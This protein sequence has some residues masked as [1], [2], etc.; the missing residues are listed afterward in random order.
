MPRKIFS[1]PRAAPP[2]N[3]RLFLRRL[4][5]RSAA[6]AVLA[7]GIYS[8]WW[9]PRSCGV[10][11][12]DIPL[13]HLPAEFD[14]LTIAFLADTHHGPCVPLG[15]LEGVVAM[16]NALRPDLV[17][18]GGDYVHRHRRWRF[19]TGNPSYIAPGIKALGGLRARL[20]CFAV[21]GNHDRLVS[22]PRTQRAL[23]ENGLRELTNTGVWLERGAARLRLCGVD[24]FTTGRPK[25]AAALGDARPGD[26][27]VLLAHNPDYVELIRDPRV[28]LALSGHTHG[29]QVVLPFVGAMLLPSKYG[30]KYA[31]GLVQAP[32]TQVFV[33]R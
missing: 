30:Q 29:G 3:R 8:T 7:A 14:G 26:A 27:V 21:L 4:A 28:G 2:I 6:G 10:T 12:V 33:T 22:G 23:A 16:T 17:A 25:L 24:D 18:L 9:E 20:G 31:S 32:A 15:Y 11:R 13:P 1:I 5:R 19:G